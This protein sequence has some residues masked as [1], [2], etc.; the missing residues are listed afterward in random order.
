MG[1]LDALLGRQNDPT[2]AWPPTE[3]AMPDFDLESMSFGPLH[4][5]CELHEAQPFGK[6]DR[7]TWSGKNT[8]ELLFAR[9]GFQLDF[10][11]DRLIYIAFFIGHD[12]F[13]PD[14]PALSLSKP[15][16]KGV[17]QLTNET[18]IGDL[19]RLFGTPTSEDRDGEEI[20]LNFSRS[21][22]VLEFELNTSGFL[23]R[24]N[25]FPEA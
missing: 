16:I 1:I 4:F 14:H 7:F 6:P 19:C 11:A 24:L 20:I 8:S 13:L 17:V 3:F 2:M 12:R 23:K 5:G 25:L 22:V 10:E 9:N 18:S 21:G 15:K